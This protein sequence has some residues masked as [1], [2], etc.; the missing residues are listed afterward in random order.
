MI[1]ILLF[2]GKYCDGVDNLNTTYDM[3]NLLQLT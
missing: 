1:Q 3:M 2:Y